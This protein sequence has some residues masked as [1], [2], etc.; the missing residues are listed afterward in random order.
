M[1]APQAEVGSRSSRPDAEN[2]KVS[3]RRPA[4]GAQIVVRG[5]SSVLPSSRSHPTIARHGESRA[6]SSRAGWTALERHSTVA[7]AIIGR[8]TIDHVRSQLAAAV[9]STHVLRAIDATVSPGLDRQS[10]TC[11]PCGGRQRPLVTSD[12]HAGLVAAIGITLTGTSRQRCRTHH[13]ANL[14]SVTPKAFQ[15]AGFT[16]SV[17]VARGRCRGKQRRDAPFPLCRR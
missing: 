14:M 2:V 3:L 12:A 6:Y 11:R 10:S 7:G 9:L 1:T 8:G 16:P 17:G 4:P 15:F 13:A 5:R